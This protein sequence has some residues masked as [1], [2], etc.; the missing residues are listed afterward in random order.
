MTTSANASPRIGSGSRLSS[1]LALSTG[2]RVFCTPSSS[3]PD[4]LS[5]QSRVP[6]WTP[7]CNGIAHRRGNEGGSCFTEAARLTLAHDGIE[8]RRWSVVWRDG[9][10]HRRHE[11]ADGV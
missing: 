2:L 11:P 9:R 4:T 7:R 6:P 5:L 3:T 8:V 10:Q 1:A